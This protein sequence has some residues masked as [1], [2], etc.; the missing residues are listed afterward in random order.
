MEEIGTTWEWLEGGNLRTISA[1]VPA[2]RTDH[3]SGRKMFFNSMVAAYTGWIDARNDPTKAV[4]LGDGS[5][6][7]GEALLKVAEFQRD[8]RICFQWKKGDVIVIDNFVTMHSRN[9]F[10]RPR[11]ILCSIG[12]PSNDGHSI[13]SGIHAQESIVGEDIPLA[14]SGNDQ[15]LPSR[16]SLLLLISTCPSYCLFLFFCFFRV[17]L[18][19]FYFIFFLASS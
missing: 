18:T 16:P 13:G 2:I 14:P 3:R 5:P 6:V 9:T 15:S 17:K 10:E 19:K 7:N 1:V 12:G 11:R 8:H 4:I